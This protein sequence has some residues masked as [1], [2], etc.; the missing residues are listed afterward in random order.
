MVWYGMASYA[1][2]NQFQ[3]YIT[4]TSVSKMAGRHTARFVKH[5]TGQCVYADG[6]MYVGGF[7]NDQCHGKGTYT[8][9][10]TTYTGEFVHGKWQAL[11]TFCSQAIM[12]R[13]QHSEVGGTWCCA[14]GVRAR[15]SEWLG[16]ADVDATSDLP[17][18]CQAGGSWHAARCVLWMTCIA[19]H[20]VMQGSRTVK[21]A[22][23]TR[24]AL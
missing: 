23:P 6:S 18:H 13:P 15:W 4:C 9:D 2:P 20:V 22:T 21:G 16:T 10:G 8:H 17:T 11:Q 3:E 12:V 19:L 5:G 24:T 14:V 7:N 1:G